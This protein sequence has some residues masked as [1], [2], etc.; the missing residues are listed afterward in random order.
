MCNRSYNVDYI[1][2]S[3]KSSNF[4]VKNILI[5]ATNTKTIQLY[6]QQKILKNCLIYNN[7]F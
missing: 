1:N 6:G 5:K 2:C 4:K 3:L 7:K